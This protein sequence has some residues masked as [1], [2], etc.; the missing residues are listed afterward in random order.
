MNNRKMIVALAAVVASM[1]AVTASADAFNG[2]YVGAGLAI[3]KMSL[4]ISG[5]GDKINLGDESHNAGLSLTAGYGASFG[6][7]YLAGELGYQTGYGKSDFGTFDLGGGPLT[8]TGQ[9]KNG[10]SASILPGY[11]FSKDTLAFARIGAVK[12]KGE[13]SFDGVS[14]SEKFSGAVYGIG[15]KHAFA[16]NI[17]ATLEYQSIVFSGKTVGGV[18]FKPTSNGVV[19]GIQ[20][21]F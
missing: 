10:W 17:A 20:Y 3:N 7:F 11:K 14:E 19:L 12:A 4:N 15:V 1:T 8:L 2:A 21:G 9:L 16:P 6:Q 13:L 5:D 18:N